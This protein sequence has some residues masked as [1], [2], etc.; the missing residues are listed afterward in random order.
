MPKTSDRSAFV[1]YAAD[2]KRSP[3]AFGRGGRKSKD[4]SK[5]KNLHEQFSSDDFFQ[6]ALPLQPTPARD[7][8]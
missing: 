6:S 4:I 7:A 5:M 1:D 8:P 3:E 2:R